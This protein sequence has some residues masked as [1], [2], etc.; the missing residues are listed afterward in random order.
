MKSQVLHTVWCHIS[1]EAA[2][3]FW[4]W[5]L[6]GVKGLIQSVCLSGHVLSYW[7]GGGE[8]GEKGEKKIDLHKFLQFQ[9]QAIIG[10]SWTQ[11]PSQK[12]QT[13]TPYII[14]IDCPKEGREFHIKG[15][16]DEISALSSDEEARKP[17]MA[18]SLSHHLKF[19]HTLEPSSDNGHGHTG[20]ISQWFSAVNY[21]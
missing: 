7:G 3:E 12:H 2:G 10:R 6:S 5:S 18:F 15:F 1:C 17:C 21:G 16:W 11:L 14:S 13:T 19:D 8:G 20:R 9:C 4:H